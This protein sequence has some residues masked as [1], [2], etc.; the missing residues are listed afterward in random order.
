MTC[1]T[2]NTKGCSDN[3]D[4]AE[5]KS[6]QTKLLTKLEGIEVTLD[7]FQSA[8]YSHCQLE[9][10]NLDLINNRLSTVIDINNECCDII[11][12]KLE[13][14][15]S[16]IENIETCNNYCAIEGDIECEVT[17]TTTEEEG[18][19][20]TATEPETTTTTT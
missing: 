19:T 17:T 2:S 3:K 16:V 18:N 14:L 13:Q 5:L 7:S 10:Q 6:T 1:N 8:L 11:N 9:G 20:T 12:L 15:A 4:Y